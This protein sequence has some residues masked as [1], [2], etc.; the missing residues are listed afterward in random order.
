MKHIMARVVQAGK[1]N[2]ERG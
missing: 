2:F 1:W